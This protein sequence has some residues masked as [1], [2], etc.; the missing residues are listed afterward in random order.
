MSKLLLVLVTISVT[1]AGCS[2]KSLY[3]TFRLVEHGKCVKEPPQAYYECIERTN[4]PYEEYERERKEISETQERIDVVVS[5][6][7]MEIRAE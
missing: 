6:K 7:S 2:N 5:Q 4:T 3:D 1:G